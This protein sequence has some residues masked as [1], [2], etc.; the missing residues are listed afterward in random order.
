MRIEERARYAATLEK[1]LAFKF[2][3]ALERDWILEHSEIIKADDGESIIEEGE[4]SPYLYA[5]LEGSANVLVHRDEKEIYI[6]MIGAGEIVG[7]A[8][9]F[10]N[11]K[12]TANVVACGETIVLRLKR[13]AFLEFLT[14]QPRG[15]SRMLLVI[16]YGLLKKLRDANQELAFER[17]ADSGQDDIDDMVANMLLGSDPLP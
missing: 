5:V 17:N 4:V 9:L 7:E 8:G 3:D 12:R 15:G 13:D 1:V 10:M 16:I 6:C 14:R 11:V 2:L